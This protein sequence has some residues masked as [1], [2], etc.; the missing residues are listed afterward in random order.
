MRIAALINSKIARLENFIKNPLIN[1]T[2]N[3]T[4]KQ[5]NTKKSNFCPGGHNFCP[6]KKLNFIYL[7]SWFLFFFKCT[8]MKG[9]VVWGKRPGGVVVWKVEG[10]RLKLNLPDLLPLT[11]F[12]RFH[13]E[14][15]WQ[16]PSL[17]SYKTSI[18]PCQWVLPN[19]TPPPPTIIEVYHVVML[20]RI[21][22][23]N[24]TYELHSGVMVSTADHIR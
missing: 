9:P 8:V 11:L 10:L 20:L 13:R 12:T 15:V 2:Y 21:Y 4:N 3:E 14:T 7:W 6:R 23:I 1:V 22:R 18:D 24:Q 17:S 16:L 19:S 5:I